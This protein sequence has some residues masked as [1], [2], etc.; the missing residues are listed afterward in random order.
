M[1]VS[2]YDREQMHGTMYVRKRT[3]QSLVCSYF[4][5]CMYACI[6]VYCNV[7]TM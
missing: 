7:V 3:V 2:M 4:H 6:V 5:I 1:H